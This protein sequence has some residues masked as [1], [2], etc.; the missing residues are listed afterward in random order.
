MK[1]R[2]FDLLRRGYSTMDIAGAYNVPEA[3]VY[4]AIH[5]Q[6]EAWR[7]ALAEHRK[8]VAA[9]KKKRGLTGREKVAGT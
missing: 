6:R 8:E 4:N 9:G 7:R 5:R 2:A 1:A 3:E